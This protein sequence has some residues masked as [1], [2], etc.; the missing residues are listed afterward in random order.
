M[1]RKSNSL[2]EYI[3]EGERSFRDGGRVEGLPSS[4]AY[5]ARLITWHVLYHTGRA[6]RDILT[7]RGHSYNVILTGSRAYSVRIADYRD[8]RAGVVGIVSA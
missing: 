5:D 3:L 2:S 1:Q 8:H 7:G 6:P 4:S